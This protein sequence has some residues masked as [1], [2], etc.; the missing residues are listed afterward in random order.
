MNERALTFGDARHLVGILGEPD[1]DRAVPEKPGVIFLNSGIL[2]RVGASRINVK[3]ARKLSGLGYPTFRFDHAGVGDSDVRRDDRSFVESAIHE[4]RT[5]MD[6]VQERKGVNRFILAG[7]CSGSDMA[8]W[9]ALEDARVVGLVQLD[10]FVYRTRK[11]MLRH[12]L[13][14]LISPAAW[15]RSIR[16]RLR[17][18]LARLGEWGGE[19]A[20]EATC[21][22]APEYTRVIPPREDLA[23]GLGQLRERGV[24]FWV[25]I[26]SGAGEVVNYSAQYAES[27]PEVAFGDGLLVDFAPEADHTLTALAQQDRVVNGVAEWVERRWGRPG[28]TLRPVP[29][30]EEAGAG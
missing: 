20:A 4:T 23:R 9:V 14:R 16:A 22:V 1:P 30:T 3:M 28:P 27:F 26:T 13:S 18:L 25:F 29:E 11:A 17:H 24:A 7:L 21:W 15:R 12:Y 5:A 19:G 10:P 6:L 2:H 8:Y